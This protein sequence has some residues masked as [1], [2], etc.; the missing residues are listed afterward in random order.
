MPTA[1]S[2][3]TVHEA[4]NPKNQSS[5]SGDLVNQLDGLDISD[6]PANAAH[7]LSCLLNDDTR[8]MPE[9]K[10]VP[11]P[12]AHNEPTTQFLPPPVITERDDFSLIL[13][14]SK[15]KDG[16]KPDFFMTQFLHRNQESGAVYYGGLEIPERDISLDEAN[17]CLKRIP[18]D[19]IYPLLPENFSCLV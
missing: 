7:S 2:T 13:E 9:N 16:G 4:D 18:E 14:I 19:D 12:K 10:G 8:P 6:A 5:I 1:D 15:I 3:S 17:N 11:R